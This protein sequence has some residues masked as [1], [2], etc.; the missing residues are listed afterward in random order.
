M[1]SLLEMT[2]TIELEKMRFY[3][4]HGVFPQE[5]A[6]GNWF[7]VSVSLTYETDAET[8]PDDNL[9]GTINYAR[10]AEIV[11]HEMSIP[12]QLLE[13]VALRIRRALLDAFAASASAASASAVSSASG[14]STAVPN[15]A[16]DAS[17][18]ITSGSIRVAKITPPLGLPLA[19]ASA[20]LRW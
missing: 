20:T 10:V 6:V 18:I 7:E 17:P 13:T 16:T 4:R 12:S 15:D 14:A 2:F 19:S 9:A 8:A 1:T 3:A 11:T 5:R